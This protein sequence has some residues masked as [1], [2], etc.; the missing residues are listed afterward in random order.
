MAIAIAVIVLVIGSLLFHF[1]SPWYFTPIASNW[2]TIDFT[3]D[4]TFW[5]TGIVF[6]AINLFMAYA[7]LRYRH[8]KGLK[9]DY[10]PENKKLEWWLTAITT[11]GVVAMLAPGLVVWAEF[12]TVPDEA[13]E[14]EAVAQQWQWSFR[15][16]G[17]D[18]ELGTTAVRFMTVDNPFGVD[19]E[20][21]NGQD[22]VLVFGNE[23]HLPIDQPM[24]ALLRSKD[25]LHDFAVPQFRVKMDL[26]PGLVTYLWFTPTRTGRFDLLCEE[27]CGLAHHTMRGDVVVDERDDF[28][29]W[30][31]TQ[32]TFAETM[33][34]PAGDPEIGRAQYASCAACHGMQGEGNLA[35]SAPKLSGQD[36]WYLR[37]QLQNYKQGRRGADPADTTGAQMAAMAG[38]LPDIAAI[39]NVVAYI[40]TLPDEPA[41]ATISGDVDR[42]QE[43]YATCGACHGRDGMGI[44]SV[45]APRQ[46]GM[47]DW[48]LANQLRKFKTGLR[49]THPQDGYGE[50]M[51]SMAMM[52]L[53][54]QAIDDVVSYINTLPK[55]RPEQL[56][57]LK[58]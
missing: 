28:E 2:D 18:G 19:P 25:V 41:P 44:W 27:L 7:I 33:A 5:V 54:D 37:R 4:I 6:V 39:N 12:V 30:L 46:A 23:V 21:E 57:D 53:D 31:E 47:N 51:A 3:V 34:M 26:V 13:D 29:A 17:K 56:A 1:L 15:F 32:P 49:G 36:S 35:L 14:F 58:P 20:D 42:G 9:A 40:D 48:Y 8:R 52:L 43:L 45:S 38:T 55:Q 22:D 16:P 11:V 50:Q 10:E 24:K